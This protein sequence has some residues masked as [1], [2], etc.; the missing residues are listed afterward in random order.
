MKALRRLAA[1]VLLATPFASPVCHAQ[2]SSQ[3][4]PSRTVKLVVPAA[5]GSTTD[6]LARIMADQL[7]RTWGKS[8]IVENISGGMV[9]GAA[10]V[11][12]SAPDGYTLMVSPPAQVAFIHLLYR[13]PGFDPQR[14]VPVALLAKVANALVAKNDLPVNDV[15]E[16]IAYA[17]ANPGKL[18]Y[19][20][21]GAG[22]TA[23]LSASQL[24]VLGD[25]TMVHVPYRGAVPALND[26]IAGHIDMFFD[27]LTTSVPMYRA[28]KVKILAVGSAERSPVVAEVPTLEESGLPGFRSVTWFALVAPPGTPA[29]IADRINAD[30]VANLKRPDVAESLAKLTLEPMI[31]SPADATAFFAEETRLWGKV[32]A[33]AHI[34]VE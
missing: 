24:E 26:V 27:T 28:G 17:K 4:F 22:S 23:H 3:A 14:F 30:V 10:T 15:R 19:G 20:S 13:D 29:S 34:K 18:T 8:V 9:L 31:G 5:A 32:I 1:I 12:R 11:F 2:E 33:A 16:L 21:Q 7:A 25:I 6:T